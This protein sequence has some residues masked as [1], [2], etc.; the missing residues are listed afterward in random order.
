VH[1]N[2][3]ESFNSPLERAEQGVFHFMSPE[4]LPWYLNEIGFR[5]AHRVPKEIVTKHRRRKTVMV[6]LPVIDMLRFLLTHAVGK[7][8]RRT[9]DSSVRVR[10]A[11]LS[12]V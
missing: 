1:N 4:H 11:I 3:A 12:S 6:A 8:L 9:M 5:W 2:T 10:I 7:Q